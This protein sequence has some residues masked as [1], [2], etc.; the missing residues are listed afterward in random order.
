[1][2]RFEA[3]RVRRASASHV[4]RPSKLSFGAWAA[5]LV[6]YWKCI[7][8]EAGEFFGL[9]TGLVGECPFCLVRRR[10]GCF[11]DR[12]GEAFAPSSLEMFL[13]SNN[14]NPHHERCTGGS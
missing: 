2:F 4:G 13:Q 8:K 6:F 12:G 7:R 9:S 14:G 10:G 11:Q 3:E 5:V 1:L